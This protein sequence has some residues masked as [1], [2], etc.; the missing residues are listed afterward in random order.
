LALLLD[1]AAAPAAAQDLRQMWPQWRGPTRDSRY[2]GEPWPDS[3]AG[4]RIAPLWRVEGLGPSYSGAIVTDALV[5]TT[6]TVEAPTT[7]RPASADGRRVGPA[8]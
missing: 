1:F 7:A 8:R 4:D 3:I 5:Y 6:A 2:H